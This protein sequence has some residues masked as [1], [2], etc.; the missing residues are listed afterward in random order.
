MSAKP[1]V[2]FAIARGWWLIPLH[3][4]I[5][6][7]EAKGWRE[8][9]SA[10]T[11]EQVRRWAE[12]GNV[13][14]CTGTN[15]GIFVIDVDPGG[16]A[17]SL[18]LPE[19]RTAETGRDGARHFYFKMPAG[20]RLSISAGRLGPNIDTRGDGGYVVLPGSVHPETGKVYRWLNDLEP[21]ELPEHIIACLTRRPVGVG[22][23][24]ATKGWSAYAR[25]AFDAEV[26]SV[27]N[28][29]AHMGN[30]ILNRAAF[31]LG[32]LVAGGQ[33][34]ESAVVEG[35]LA[36]ATPRRPELEARKTIASGMSK[37]MA[38]P[39]HPR[40]RPRQ[41]F[42]PPRRGQAVTVYGRMEIV[43][44]GPHQF[45]PDEWVPMPPNCGL[46]RDDYYQVSNHH[47]VTAVVKALPADVLYSRG[48]VIGELAGPP[49]QMEFRQLNVNRSRAIID[50]HITL[51]RWNL[52]RG[53]NAEPER[54]YVP[55]N[56]DLAKLVLSSA[57]RCG[58]I[59]RLLMLVNYP[60]FYGPECK[61]ANPGWNAEAGLYYDQPPALQQL[62]PITDEARIHATLWDLLVDFP[63]DSSASRQNFFGLMLTPLV[64]PA[65]RGNVPLHLIDSSIERAGKS[66]L[67]EQILGKTVLGRLVP[68]AQLSDNEEERR[69]AILSLL[70]MART[71]VHLD[72]LN[73]HL[74]SGA[75]ASV[76]T[77]A[78]IAGRLLGHSQDV[79]VTNT[80]TVVATGNKVRMSSEL[81][82]RTVPIM[83][84]PS[85]DHPELRTDFVHVDLEEYLSEKRLEILGCLIGMV[86]RWQAAGMPRFTERP[87]G[88]FEDWAAVVGGILAYN[89][90]V[91][92]RTSDIRWQ[93]V[94]NTD[95]VEL[96]TFVAEW[97]ARLSTPDE[98]KPA[99]WLYDLAD[100]MDLFG[101]YRR[102]STEHGRRVSFSANVLSRH[103]D[104]P[105]CGLYI[106]NSKYGNAKRWGLSDQRP[107]PD[108]VES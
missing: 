69:K 61:P 41:N 57:A 97:R 31:N 103:V 37:G 48:E 92:W 2:E 80:M 4:K 62:I 1:D 106:T 52:S 38:Q 13:G 54:V 94:A 55:C 89:G 68:A 9:P 35:L 51:I 10:P 99:Q 19:T 72:N 86:H 98:K 59:R 53:K 45:N 71:V 14:V 63:F 50:E 102:A 44:P 43:T 40:G 101:K 7:K 67:V 66:K 24:P 76:I 11:P 18:N 60:V 91:D 64:R 5:P 105:I 39:R 23:G 12:R 3:G 28:A 20:V 65:L 85:T 8:W 83:L 47:F 108:S 26:S 49:G 75:L 95:Q 25:T 96:E 36:A 82:K 42:A 21:A 46:R 90:F 22:A 78:G 88:G 93:Q 30:D 34:E 27:V 107:L 17:A 56:E 70:L 32:Q 87:M 104:R 15:S 58:D 16:D 81:A 6:T 73:T 79:E 77:A 100:E 84:R 74:D 33:L 29:P